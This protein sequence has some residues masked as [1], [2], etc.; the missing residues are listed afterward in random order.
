MKY[1]TGKTVYQ[2]E[3]GGLMS[4]AWQAQ[5]LE[6]GETFAMKVRVLKR[7][8]HEKRYEIIGLLNGEIAYHQTWMIDIHGATHYS[9]LGYLPNVDA[10]ISGAFDCMMGKLPK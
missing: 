9:A 1:Q 8:G 5:N 6:T 3:T 7:L 2:V 10:A 4:S